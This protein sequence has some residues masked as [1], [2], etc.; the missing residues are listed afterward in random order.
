VPTAYLGVLN[1]AVH[2]SCVKDEE[3]TK[4]FRYIMKFGANTYVIL[5][6]GCVKGECVEEKDLGKTSTSISKALTLQ[7]LV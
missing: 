4:P 1:S 3:K 6:Y 7:S 5:K 2:G